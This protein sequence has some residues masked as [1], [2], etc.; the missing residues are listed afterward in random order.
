MDK[1]KHYGMLNI[2]YNPTFGLNEKTI[3]VNIFDFDK[4]LYGKILK[5][6]FLKFI[7]N[8]IKFDNAEMLQNRLLEDR[9]NCINYIN[10]TFNN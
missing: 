2:G 6:D 3:E 8:E 4:D 7:R 1:E 9:E 5:I 10:S